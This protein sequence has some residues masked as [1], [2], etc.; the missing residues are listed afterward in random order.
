LRHHGTST[1]DMTRQQA[2]LSHDASC[3]MNFLF[4]WDYC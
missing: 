4:S 3:Q 2:Q 1:Y